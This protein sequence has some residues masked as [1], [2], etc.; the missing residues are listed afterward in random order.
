MNSATRNYLTITAG[1]WAFTTTGLFTLLDRLD[2]LL[3]ASTAMPITIASAR[4]C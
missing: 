2:L 1:Y 3:H 4:W